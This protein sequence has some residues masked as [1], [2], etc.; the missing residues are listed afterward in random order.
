MNGISILLIQITVVIAAVRLFGWMFRRL[1]QPPVVGEMVAGLALGPSL[2]GL[3]APSVSA[4]LFPAESLKVLDGLSQIGLVLFMFVIGSHVNAY[5]VRRSGRAAILIS[6]AS[7]SIPFGMGF[8]LAW[9]L[10]GRVPGNPNVP[11]LAFALFVG[12]AMSI[13]ALLVL[14]RILADRGMTA[15]RVGTLAIVC[16]AINDVAGWAILAVV[17]GFVQASQEAVSLRMLVGAAVYAVFMIFGLRP[18]VRRFATRGGFAQGG[19]LSEDGF[20]LFL[21]LAFG[22]ALVTHAI[23]IHSLFGAFLAGTII[24]KRPGLIGPLTE[25]LQPLT[26]TILLPFFFALTGLRTSLRLIDSTES[27]LL[28]L[29]VLVVAVAGKLGGTYLAARLADLSRLDA[30]TLGVLMNTRGLMELVILNIGIEIGVIS[31]AVFA[32]LVVMAVV[33]TLMPSPILDWI[34][35]RQTPAGTAIPAQVEFDGK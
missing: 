31:P 16:A 33:T 17:V 7:I 8:G 21:L 6:S 30:F 24:P 4:W 12:A 32:M 9:F 28:A 22:S 29:L 10:N 1:G 27:W 23:G 5:E 2:L 34:R 13:T 3:V 15:T 25:R 20:V 35:A 14:A 11:P 26:T 19:V 18:L